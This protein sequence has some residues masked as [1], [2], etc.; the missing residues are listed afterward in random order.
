MYYDRGIYRSMFILFPIPKHTMC[1][2][3]GQNTLVLYV[4]L[5]WLSI[6]TLELD[7]YSS[8]A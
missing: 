5:F 8:I 6:S 4:P 7:G 1:M 2:H 3:Y